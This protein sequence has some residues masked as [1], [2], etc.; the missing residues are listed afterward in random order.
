M[1]Q[2]KFLTNS[3]ER[4][5]LLKRQ[6][7]IINPFDKSKESYYKKYCESNWNNAKII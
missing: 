6:K 3:L 2:N 4:R 5:I 7:P 1:S